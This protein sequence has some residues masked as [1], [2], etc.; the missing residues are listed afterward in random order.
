MGGLEETGGQFDCCMVTSKHRQDDSRVMGLEAKSLLKRGLTM[1]WIGPQKG[2]AEEFGVTYRTFPPGLQIFRRVL[3]LYRAVR[4]TRAKVFHCHEP[5]ACVV[6]LLARRPG[7]R[8]IFDAHEFYRAVARKRMPLLLKGVASALYFAFEMVLYRRCDR[9][10]TVSEG[11]ADEM[12]KAAP[13]RI[14]T[15]VA[16]CSGPSR[17]VCRGPAL[18]AAGFRVLHLGTASFYHQIREMLE[19]FCIVRQQIPQ[20]EFVQIGAL[21]EEEV[22]WLAAFS[23]EKHLGN[24]VLVIPRVRFDDLGGYVP[25]ADVGLIA[26]CADEN[27]NTSISTKIFDYMTFGLPVVATDLRMLRHLNEKYRVASLVDSSSPEAIASAIVELATDEELRGLYS[28]NAL[29]AVREEY[30]WE[31]M[32]KR[33]FGVYDDLLG[34]RG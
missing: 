27:A 24:S 8:V 22:R 12:R 18:P 7:E 31:I 5:E 34:V 9:L 6:A 17:L 29:S 2:D 16:N 26:R 21:P 1:A 32:E 28:R 11:V 25:Y 4:Q 19:A 30:S 3:A 14:P 15:I 10:V 33:L 13:A 23:Q 20:A